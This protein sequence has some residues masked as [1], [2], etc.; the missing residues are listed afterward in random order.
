MTKNSSLDK[1]NFVAL[2]TFK[3]NG[4]GVITPTW[5]TEENDKY[6]IWTD[7]DSWKVKRIR[8]NPNVRICKSDARGTPKDDWF[9][10]RVQILDSDD[11]RQK[12]TSLFL[13]KYRLQFRLFAFMGKRAPKVILEIEL[14]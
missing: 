2:E 14:L 8:N 7:R 6:Y 13:S 3:K 1:A 5:V 9:D 10:A 11:A 4:D 12:A